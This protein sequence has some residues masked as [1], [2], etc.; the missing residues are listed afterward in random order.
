MGASGRL[1]KQ[2]SASTGGERGAIRG[3]QA[4]A[5][6]AVQ[7]FPH[8][9]APGL[10]DFRIQALL[11]GGVVRLG[12]TTGWAAVG[13]TGFIRLQLEFFGADDAGFHRKRH[14]PSIVTETLQLL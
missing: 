4:L 2:H 12:L 3:A 1:T 9:L 8:R 11:A 13:E 6:L 14:N 5:I 7:K 10:I